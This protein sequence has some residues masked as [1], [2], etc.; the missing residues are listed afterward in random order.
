MGS[1]KAIKLGNL[2]ASRDWG[3]AEEYVHAYRQIL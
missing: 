2:D 3:S 1:K